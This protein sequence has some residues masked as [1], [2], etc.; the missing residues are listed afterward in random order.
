MFNHFFL[1]SVSFLVGWSR[2][3]EVHGLVQYV[4]VLA[5]AVLANSPDLDTLLECPRMYP[6]S[7]QSLA[8]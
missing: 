5:G 7:H 1:I 4:P 3:S 2:G 8:G 6:P